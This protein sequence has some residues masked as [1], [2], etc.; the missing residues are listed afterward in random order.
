V[1]KGDLSIVASSLHFAM[2]SLR[3]RWDDT[4]AVWND[5]VRKSFEEKHVAPLEPQVTSTLK[6]VNRLAQVLARAYEE[7]S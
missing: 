2:K 4:Q 7:C 6:A 3:E 5:S 1:K